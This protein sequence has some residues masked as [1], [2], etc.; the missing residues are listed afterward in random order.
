MIFWILYFLYPTF[1]YLL[2][3]YSPFS[4]AVRY[5]A[6][7]RLT[8]KGLLVYFVIFIFIPSISYLNYFSLSFPFF[9]FHQSFLCNIALKNL[10]IPLLPILPSVSNLP[11]LW[12]FLFVILLLI[13]S[14]HPVT[15]FSYAFL[16]SGSNLGSSRPQEIENMSSREDPGLC[17]AFCGS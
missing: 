14:L 6:T 3:V 13:F 4:C 2:S 8:P 12:L 1:I 9:L 16:S 11:G 17:V 10:F 7:L 5:P 15:P